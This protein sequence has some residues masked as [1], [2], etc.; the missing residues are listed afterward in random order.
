MHAIIGRNCFK[1]NKERFC[2]Q[3]INFVTKFPLEHLFSET[4]SQ[5]P[6]KKI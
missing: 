5:L 3:F 4:K 2:Q 1:Q 6:L